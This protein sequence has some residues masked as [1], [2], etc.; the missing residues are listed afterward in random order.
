MVSLC[1]AKE[2]APSEAELGIRR[3]NETSAEKQNSPDRRSGL[4]WIHHQQP[5]LRFHSQLP[6]QERIHIRE[7][8][9]L[10]GYWLACA[11]T[12]LGFYP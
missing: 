5:T 10:L 3:L 12:G 2:P 4:W 1:F 8:L 7:L 9:D 6:E 11:V